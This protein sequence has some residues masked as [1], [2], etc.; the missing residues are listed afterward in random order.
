MT[1]PATAALIF[2][3]PLVVILAFVAAALMERRRAM[4]AG[5]ARFFRAQRNAGRDFFDRRRRFLGADPDRLSATLYGRLFLPSET[6]ADQ[7]RRPGRRLYA[8][9]LPLFPVRLDAEHG[10]LERHPSQC[11]LDHDFRLDGDHDRQFRDLLSPRLFHGAGRQAA[12]RAETDGAA[13]DP[14][15]DQRN[16]ARLRL[17]H[18][19]RHRRPHQQCRDR[20]RPHSRAHRFHR[21]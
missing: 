18:S 11:V 13:G 3:L 15:L 19:A 17:P 10:A 6:A 7:A 1:N 12:D 9:E 14:L 20:R 5:D 21:P 8:G 16:P 2:A 4:A